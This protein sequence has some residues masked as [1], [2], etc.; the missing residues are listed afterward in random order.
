MGYIL[1]EYDLENGLT[2]VVE[3]FED[4]RI[5]KVVRDIAGFKCPVFYQQTK[6]GWKKTG[7]M[8]V[9]NY[10]SFYKDLCKDDLRYLESLES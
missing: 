1:K 2:E 5:C 3:Y 4:G 7:V 8:A 9:M 10:L 6:K